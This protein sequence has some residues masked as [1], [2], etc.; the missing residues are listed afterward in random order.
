MKQLGE[1]S[2]VRRLPMIELQV[3]APVDLRLTPQSIRQRFGR[4]ARVYMRER[5]NE[6]TKS[7]VQKRYREGVR[8]F[9][10]RVRET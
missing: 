5:S 7:E 3:P 9:E 2:C 10:M 8:S 1:V 4:V 6:V